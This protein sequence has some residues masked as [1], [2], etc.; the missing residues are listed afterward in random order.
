MGS[1][2]RFGISTDPVIIA[3][4]LRQRCAPEEPLH[5]LSKPGEVL[6]IANVPFKGLFG[7]L[8]KLQTLPDGLSRALLLVELLGVSSKA[9]NTITAA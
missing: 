2:L 4:C 1:L 8:E 3:D 7:F 9:K 6:E 5:E